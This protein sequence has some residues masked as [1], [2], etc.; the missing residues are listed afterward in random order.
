MSPEG[1]VSPDGR[2]RQARRGVA[3]PTVAARVPVLPMAWWGHETFWRDYMRLRRPYL[4]VIFGA[5]LAIEAARD[6]LAEADR[7][8]RRIAL[9]LPAEY[10][11]VYADVGECEHMLDG[12]RAE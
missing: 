4:R 5:P 8:M 7:V 1:H 2:L 6:P 11:G 9:L 12:G 3:R 10:R